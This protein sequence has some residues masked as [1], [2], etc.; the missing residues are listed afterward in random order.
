MMDGTADGKRSSP[1]RGMTRRVAAR[2]ALAGS[3]AALGACGPASLGSGSAEPAGTAATW[4]GIQEIEF[5]GTTYLPVLEAYRRLSQKFHAENP[6]V[7]LSG[8]E[9]VAKNG[10]ADVLIP[11]VAGGTPPAAAELNQPNTWAFAGQDIYGTL[12]DYIRRDR[13]TSQALADF[14]P[15]QLEAVTW[16]DRLYFLPVGVS[17][18]TWHANRAFWQRAGLET[19]KDGWTWSDLANT[20][21]PK[22]KGAVG[23]DGSPLMVELNEMYRVLA[24]IKQ[25]GAD[26][27]DKGATRLTLAEPATVEAFAFLRDLVVKG[28]V[29]EKDKEAKNFLMSGQHVALELEGMTRIPTYRKAIGDDLAWA[30]APKQ[31]VRASVYDSWV[32]GLVKSD[33]PRK[34]EA[35]YQWLSWLIRPENNLI[36][37]VARANLPARR[38]V[39]QQP[40]AADLWAAEPLIK[41]AL[42][43]LN[44]GTTFPFTPATGHIRVALN[45]Q[46]LPAI[47][48]DGQ[49][50]RQTLQQIGPIL[51]QQYGPLLT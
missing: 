47:L 13:T 7:R 5:W 46:V 40:G 22:L 24:F 38:A 28:I 45:Q 30:P 39:A 10:V 26:L 36:Y 50:A 21:G 37:Q 9:A 14:Y 16:R 6:R 51:E 19:P 3:V 42:D 44:Y 8:G 48:R 49:P 11:A 34:M 12:N 33:D 31:K 23:P 35:A 15:G 4:D 2:G 41:A 29:V 1:S 18:E 20:Y 32:V 17:M 25:N 27:F 43:D